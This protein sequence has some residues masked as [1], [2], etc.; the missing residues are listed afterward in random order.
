LGPG[1]AIVVKEIGDRPVKQLFSRAALWHW[2]GQTRRIFSATLRTL[3]SY[4]N[5]HTGKKRRR[6]GF[7]WLAGPPRTEKPKAASWKDYQMTV[8]KVGKNTS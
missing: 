5:K 8:D 4:T 1:A 3:I 6:D 2:A 7:Y